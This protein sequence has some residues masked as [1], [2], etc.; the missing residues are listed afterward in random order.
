VSEAPE[1]RDNPWEDLVVA[2]LAVNQYSL[3][4]TYTLVAGLR[5]AGIT[6]ARNLALWGQEQMLERLRAAGC[7]RGEFMTTLFAKR[8]CGLG[9]LIRLAGVDACDRVL[10]SGDPQAIEALLLP[11]N[12]VGPKVLKNFSSLR[13]I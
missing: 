7:E 10:A 11:V 3:E 5:E 9:E 6:D 1:G 12:G 2:I 13:E 4:K 8:L